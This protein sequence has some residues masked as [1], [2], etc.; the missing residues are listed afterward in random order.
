VSWAK[1]FA[2]IGA[3][4]RIAAI[5]WRDEVIRHHAL[6]PHIPVFTALDAV[7]VIRNMIHISQSA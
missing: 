6:I 1:R 2:D 3:G 7:P 4:H 5:A